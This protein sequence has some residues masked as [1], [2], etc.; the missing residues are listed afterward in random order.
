MDRDVFEVRRQAFAGT[1]T[2]QRL[3]WKSPDIQGRHQSVDVR[4]WVDWGVSEVRIQESGWTGTSQG[5]KPASAG[6]GTS[7]R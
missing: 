6:T 2:S 7:Q 4:I 1:G 3:E 5:E